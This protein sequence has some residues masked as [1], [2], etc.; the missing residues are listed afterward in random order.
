MPTKESD[1][2]LAI[3]V[4]QFTADLLSWASHKVSDLEIAKDLVQDTF[5]AASEKIES[6]RGDS[7]PKTWL[8]SILKYKIIDHYRDK[9]KNNTFIVKQ[10]FESLFTEDGEWLPDKK[11]TKWT[12]NDEHLLD[13]NNFNAVLKKCFDA[14]PEKWS[15]SIKL[16][17]LINKKAEN[18]C[19]ELNISTTNYWQ[20]LHRAKLQLRECIDKKWFKDKQ[21]A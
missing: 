3:W 20:I 2:N 14:L 8:F 5:L 6:F 19:Q 18:I 21:T 9:V 16:K 12:E 1:K 4:K 15:A 7:S 10:S 13:N 11:P 17:Y